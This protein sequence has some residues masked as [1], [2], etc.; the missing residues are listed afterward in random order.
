MFFFAAKRNITDKFG[1]AK[2]KKSVVYIE[3]VLSMSPF[4]QIKLS[5]KQSNSGNHIE[6]VQKM[7]F[8]MSYTADEP[9]VWTSYKQIINFARNEY[10][11]VGVF[12]IKMRL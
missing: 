5:I 2:Y 11:R 6:I 1:V 7:T 9:K 8:F 10:E 4:S 12:K 3:P